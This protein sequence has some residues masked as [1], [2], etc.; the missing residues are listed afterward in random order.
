[1]KK[2]LFTVF[3]ILIAF[4][5]FCFVI[6]FLFGILTKDKLK[7]HNVIEETNYFK[8]TQYDAMYYCYIYN[9]NHGLVKKDGPFNKIP[10]IVLT[11]DELVRLTLQAGTGIETQW[12]YFYDINRNKISEI[13]QSIYDQS[14]QKVAYGGLDKVVVQDI[15]DRSKYYREFSS[16]TSPF[17]EVTM[18]I[19]DVKFIKGGT[20]IEISYLT[21]ANYEIVTE[22]IEL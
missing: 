5:F 14:N 8:I 17:S 22:V 20:S 21:G 9:K 13:F 7:K 19:L 1:M 10:E 18:P 2:K 11:E 15:F 16:F 3:L 12:G 6:Y 4:L